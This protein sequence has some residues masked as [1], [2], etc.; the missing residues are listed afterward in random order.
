MSIPQ[1]IQV[2]ESGPSPSGAVRDQASEIN[3]ACRT[4][5]QEL[6]RRSSD[7]KTERERTEQLIDLQRNKTLVP[8]IVQVIQQSIPTNTGPLA[9]A[10]SQEEV[11]QIIQ[12]G[13][14]PRKQRTQVIIEKINLQFEPDLDAFVWPD[15]LVKVPER[16]AGAGGGGF[17]VK[18]TCRTPNEGGP[19]YISDTL[20]TRM[21]ELGRKAGTNFYFDRIYLIN[22]GKFEP[23]G[24]T[25]PGGFGARP[26]K[27]GDV[28]ATDRDPITGESLL[29]DWEFEVWA[30]VILEEY[31]ELDE[32]S[33]DDE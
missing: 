24:T 32:E 12:S 4:L 13:S 3:D 7:G 2:V 8:R 10:S 29:D 30:D 17:E 21:R 25:R 9:S 26:S 19:K 18:I 33:S 15:S 20:M 28:A 22:G 23:K 14:S 11:L 31:P 16:I 6:N 5:K 1:A 27:G